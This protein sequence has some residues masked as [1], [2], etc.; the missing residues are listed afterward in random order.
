MS[1]NWNI[2]SKLFV[3][4][5]A[6]AAAMIV[7]VWM[8]FNT[9]EKVG[10][11]DEVVEAELIHL[12]ALVAL[13]LEAT[14]L[15]LAAMDT[16]VDKEEGRILD[17]RRQ[18]I[19]SAVAKF[20]SEQGRLMEA[21]IEAGE[22][23]KVTNGRQFGERIMANV[24]KL[25]KLTL[26]EMSA[27]LRMQSESEFDRLDGAIDQAGEQL[28]ADLA[29]LQAASGAELRDAMDGVDGEVQS[30]TTTAMT[31]LAAGLVIMGVV[32]GILGFSITRPIAM[33][34]RVMGDLANGKLDVDVDLTRRDEVGAMAKAVQIFKDNAIEKQRL[35]ADQAAAALR[36]EEEKRQAMLQLADRFEASVKEVVD[37]VSSAATEM[38]A[39]SQQMSATAEET[40]RQSANVATASDQASANV[41]TVA[42]TAEELSA[43]IAEIGRASCRERVS[44]CV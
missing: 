40:S 28:D 17:E 5:A 32:M 25:E 10:E 26:A 23:G 9:A 36:A 18:V 27:A 12:E 38:Q 7:L 6:T 3:M 34:T 24:D 22:A 39:T 20:R 13:R 44:N 37:G 1:W 8:F 30:A 42:A 15:V 16:L 4:A 2:K 19:E 29:A 11:A 41:Q 43:S 33:L 14:E 35:E 21:A 31:I